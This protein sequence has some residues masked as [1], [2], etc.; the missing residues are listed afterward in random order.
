M[1]FLSRCQIQSLG[2]PPGDR[3]LAHPRAPARLS[4]DLGLSRAKAARTEGNPRLAALLFE[5]FE[6][7]VDG[8]NVVVKTGR[9]LFADSADFFY[10][11]IFH[12]LSIPSIAPAYIRMG[13]LCIL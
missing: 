5:A 2:G 12:P 11:F 7:R 9:V 1:T 6:I 10:D 13:I 8:I 4:F 3:R